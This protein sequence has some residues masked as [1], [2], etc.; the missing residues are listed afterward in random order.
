MIEL[1]SPAKNLEFGI[2]AISAGADAVYIGAHK[3][4]ARVN[5][6]NNLSDIKALI[7]Y[8]HKFNVKVYVVLN[9]ILYDK[10]IKEV[11][12]T[13]DE[14]Y[15]FNVDGLIIQD[16]G[17][18]ELNL[19]DIP[20]IGST[21]MNNVDISQIKFF[22]KI[23]F[24]RVILARELSLKEIKE[25]KKE[26]KIE[27]EA[28]IHG[29][30]CV[31]YSGRCYMSQYLAN[32]SGNR[33]ECIQPCR[34]PY[35]LVDSEG[36]ILAKD[37]YLLSL[38]DL[39]SE[40]DIEELIDAGITSFKIEGRLK[41]IDYVLN[42]TYYYRQKIDE[43]L[44]KKKLKKSSEGEVFSEIKPDLEKTFNRSFTNY[45]RHG[46]QKDILAINSPKSLGKLMGEVKQF[47][48]NYF[49]LNKRQKFVPG[50]GV[51]FFNKEGELKGSN[52][53]KIEGEKVFL[54][55]RQDLR[56]G[57][58]VY[59]NFDLEFNKL[60]TNKNSFQRKI[61]IKVSLK[62]TQKGIYVSFK[63]GNSFVSE[64]I[65]ISKDYANDKE[66]SFENIKSQFSKL[67]NTDFYLKEIKID[68]FKEPLFIPLSVLNNLRRDLV[69]KLD[70][71]ISKNYKREK[72]KINKESAEPYFLKD[73][74]YE[75][76]VSNKLARNFYIKHGVSKID[77][78]FEIKKG[79]K[80]MTTKHCLKN[81]LGLCGD[82]N[83]KEPLYL[84][85]EKKQKFLLK[86][87]C[88]KCQMEI[89]SIE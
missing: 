84:I 61:G 80:L 32:K 10:E 64:E 31:S 16:V 35:S 18:L 24:K 69:Q 73:L 46:R 1:L 14:L 52:V 41:D 86:F 68:F 83:L 49:I 36:K 28:F 81:Y 2:A 79:D 70:D 47:S 75:N 58:K 26:T 40:N 87:N 67:G 8:A 76:N 37:K 30:L 19:Y 82:P 34:L 39:S 12:K 13:I 62:E 33:G 78:A 48:G 15:F 53:I 71:E 51:C 3:F 44:K 29:A 4:G 72:G 56:L 6:S 21:Q 63:A 25:I 74:S 22:E 11:Q 66:L 59:R 77:S 65:E 43:I 88:K 27:L 50:D 38:K 45:F 20:I 54:N 17:I 55:E 23:G 60:I 89:Y 7:S 57:D 85:N 5:A 42:T 9:T